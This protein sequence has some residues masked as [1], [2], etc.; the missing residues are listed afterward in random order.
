MG[1]SLQEEVTEL[2]FQHCLPVNW[3]Q[4]NW[5]SQYRHTIASRCQD[6]MWQCSNKNF[7]TSNLRYCEEVQSTCTAF[8][9]RVH[10]IE[11]TVET[12][13]Q[14]PYNIDW[15]DSEDYLIYF[16]ELLLKR[17]EQYAPFD[18]LLARLGIFFDTEIPCSRHC[19][20]LCTTY[21]QKCP[22]PY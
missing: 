12:S 9:N 6:I 8:V 16:T 19:T 3:K 18:G 1:S 21:Q 15:F 14:W 13:L 17:A 10:G 7:R 20:H 22:L 5:Y 2:L 4:Y 11:E